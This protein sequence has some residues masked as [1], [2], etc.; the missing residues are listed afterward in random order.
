MK[1]FQSFD[2]ERKV[3]LYEQDEDD[4]KKVVKLERPKSLRKVENPN[5]GMY[6]VSYTHLTL[7]T[8]LLV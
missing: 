3:L 8:I 6:P 4:K 7:P 5:P 1:S 2:E